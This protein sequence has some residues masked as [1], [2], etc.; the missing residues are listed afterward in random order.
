VWFQAE[1]EGNRVEETTRA[2]A[3]ESRSLSSLQ[4]AAGSDFPPRY[5]KVVWALPGG[6]SIRTVDGYTRSR[7][8]RCFADAGALESVEDDKSR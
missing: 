4:L 2:V 8:G 6:K 1:A 5:L 7:V 3:V